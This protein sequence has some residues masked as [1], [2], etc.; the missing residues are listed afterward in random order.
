VCVALGNDKDGCL[1]KNK[2]NKNKKKQGIVKGIAFII[3]RVNKIYCPEFS[4]AMPAR[5]SGKGRLESRQSI[6]K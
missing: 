6:E 1:K 2:N 5:P 3:T 4:Q